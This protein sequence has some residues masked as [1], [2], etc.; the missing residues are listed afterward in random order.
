MAKYVYLLNRKKMYLDKKVYEGVVDF[1]I[2]WNEIEAEKMRLCIGGHKTPTYNAAAI[3]LLDKKG[4]LVLP[5]KGHGLLSIGSSK[6]GYVVD[7][8]TL[9]VSLMVMLSL[10]VLFAVYVANQDASIQNSNLDSTFKNIFHTSTGGFAP[11]VDKGL[12]V[13]LVIMV[14]FLLY[15]A[16]TIGSNFSLFLL[17]LLMNFMA[18]FLLPQ[19]EDFLVASYYNNDY[20]VAI[21]N[22]PAT[23]YI[24]NHYTIFLTGIVVL[25]MITFFIR[26]S[27]EASV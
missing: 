2:S 6:K 5:K 13:G 18:L 21:S 12:V 26:P 10:I 7:N 15:T 24:I 8:I 9:L 11:A 22:M 14:S 25:L 16:Y 3:I 23:F 17:A 27:G 1:G 20:A 19:A 4:G